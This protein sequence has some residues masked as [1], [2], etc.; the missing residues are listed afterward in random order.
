[1]NPH[2]KW[3][4]N[5]R[6]RAYG[7]PGEGHVVIHSQKERRYQCKRCRR[8][9][10]ETKGTALY[11]SHKPRWLMIAVLTLLAYGCPVQAVVAA[12]DLD[13]RTVARWQRESGSQCKRV[14]ESTS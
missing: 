4:H 2:D 7:R 13:E 8:T 12:F 11:R 3:C 14:H 6:C 1:M 10:T 5:P 9:F